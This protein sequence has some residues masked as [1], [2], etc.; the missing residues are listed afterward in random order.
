MG[1]DLHG[2]AP[3]QNTEKPEILN[4][5]RSGGKLKTKVFKNN[6]TMSMKL[7]KK[8]T[9]AYILG[10]MYGGGDHYGIIYVV[11]VKTYLLKRI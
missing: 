7:G 1:F 10:T 9:Q 2:I 11:V 8:K 4:K 6:T 5:Y 3:K